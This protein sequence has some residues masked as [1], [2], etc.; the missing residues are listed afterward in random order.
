[1]GVSAKR[2]PFLDQRFDAATLYQLR[3]AVAAHAAEIGLPADQAN[4]ILIAVHELAGNAIRHGTGHGRLCMWRRGQA[5]VF[6]VSDGDAGPAGEVTPPAAF[7]S[8]DPPGELPW[9]VETGHGL[10]LVRQIASHFAMRCD[11]SGVTATV[12]FHPDAMKAGE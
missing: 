12:V 5:L 11:D 3:A 4:D 2:S 1:V 10:W 8:L 7:E 6:T 9:P